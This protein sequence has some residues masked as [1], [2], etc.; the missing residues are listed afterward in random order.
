MPEKDV[1]CLCRV[2]IEHGKRNSFA[3]SEG[4]PGIVR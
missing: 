1:V 2:H 3:K 4:R